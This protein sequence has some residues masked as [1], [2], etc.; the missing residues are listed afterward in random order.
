MMDFYAIAVLK[1]PDYQYSLF[2]CLNNEFSWATSN[3]LKPF[4]AAWTGNI[5]FSPNKKIPSLVFSIS[6]YFDKM[7]MLFGRDALLPKLLLLQ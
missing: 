2:A 5:L 7:T 4:K 3:N 6:L 1:T